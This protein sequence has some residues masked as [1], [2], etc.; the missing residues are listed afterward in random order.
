MP[1]LFGHKQACVCLARKWLAVAA[2]FCVIIMV[3]IIIIIIIQIQARGEP[4]EVGA[5]T[6]SDKK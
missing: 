1:K 5:I 2:S 6:M 4:E 3:I